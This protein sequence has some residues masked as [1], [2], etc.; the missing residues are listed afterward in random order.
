MKSLPNNREFPFEATPY[1][2]E[3]VGSRAGDASSIGVVEPFRWEEMTDMTEAVEGASDDA[4]EA[5]V[6]FGR[7]FGADDAEVRFVSKRDEADLREEEAKRR[8][9]DTERRAEEILGA[10]RER[11]K[12]LEEEARQNGYALGYEEGLEKG[13]ADAEI[14]QRQETE[15]TL[16]RYLGEIGRTIEAIQAQKDRLFEEYRDGLCDL[17]MSVAEKVIN[18]SLKSSGQVIEKM[19]VAATEHMKNKQWV[20][21]SVSKQDVD[22]MVQ[23]DMDILAAVRNVSDDVKVVVVDDAEPGTCVV[24]FPDQIIDASVSTQLKNIKEILT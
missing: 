6:F 7:D 8:M 24:E 14:R 22:L 20:K 18:I 16:R 9:S 4:A 11:A 21:I 19:I 13:R 3:D 5:S 2:L 12:E 15:Q 17:A 10:A 1:L 23:G